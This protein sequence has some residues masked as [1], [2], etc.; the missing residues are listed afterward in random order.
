[1]CKEFQYYFICGHHS[2]HHNLISPAERN[3]CPAV[4]DARS[5]GLGWDACPVRPLIRRTIKGYCPNKWDCQRAAFKRLGWICHLCDGKKK[6]ELDSCSSCNHS[7]CSDC[8]VW[9]WPTGDD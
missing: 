5:R 4:S 6:A 7:P 1:M 8:N 9:N 2:G 3:Q